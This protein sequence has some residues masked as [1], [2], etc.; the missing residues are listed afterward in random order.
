VTTANHLYHTH[1][2]PFS[3]EHIALVLGVKVCKKLCL[4]TITRLNFLHY[5]VNTFLLLENSLTILLCVS[6]TPTICNA[7]DSFPNLTP[8]PNITRYSSHETGASTLI[9]NWLTTLTQHFRHLYCNSKISAQ[10][11]ECLLYVL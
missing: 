9:Y 4:K 3:L 10:R 6:S 1:L 11:N 7:A 2:L 5:S 8:Q